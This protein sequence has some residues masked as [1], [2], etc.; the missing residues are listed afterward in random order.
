MAVLNAELTEHLGHEHGGTP[1]EANMRNGTRVKT[2]LTE[3]GP[4]ETGGSP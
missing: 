3:I 2:V 1:I 4:V